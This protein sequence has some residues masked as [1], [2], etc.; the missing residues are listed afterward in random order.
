MAGQ[1]IPVGAANGVS[2]E[3][4][5]GAPAT[6]TVVVRGEGFTGQVPVR[7]VVTPEHTAATV[8]DLTLDAAANPPEVSTQITLPEGE[9]VRLHAWTR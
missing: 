4:P 6:Q 2:F 8:Y 3:L 7:L 5:A 1:S 9:P